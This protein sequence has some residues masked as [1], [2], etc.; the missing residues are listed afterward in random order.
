[1]HNHCFRFLLGLLQYPGVIGNDGYHATLLGGGGLTRCI[2]VYVK[3]MN[4]GER[5]KKNVGYP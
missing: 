5:M 3:M 2:I 1:M 4:S